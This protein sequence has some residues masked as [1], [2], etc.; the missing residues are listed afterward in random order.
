M[1]SQLVAVDGSI[2]DTYGIAAA[3]CWGGIEEYPG[4]GLQTMS[5]PGYF[6]GAQTAE[7]LAVLLALDRIKRQD[8]G[9]GDLLLYW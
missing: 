4:T 8:P 5:R 7:L 3:V 9:S 2:D 1:E 6:V